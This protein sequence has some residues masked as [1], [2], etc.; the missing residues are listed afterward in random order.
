MKKLQIAGLAAAVI[1]V[2]G[3]TP[4][5]AKVASGPPATQSYN[6]FVQGGYT[7][8]RIYNE[9]SAGSTDKGSSFVAS[10]AYLYFPFALKFDFRQDQFRTANNT[11]Q[12]FTTVPSFGGVTTASAVFD[13]RQSTFDGRLE[14]QLLDPHIYLGV[15][16][17]RA[18]NNYGYP[19]LGGL[20]LG[21]EK[22]PEFV[23]A[24]GAHFSAFYYPNVSGKFTVTDPANPN[25]N[26]TYTQAYRILK[27]DVGFDVPITQSPVYVSVGFSGDRYYDKANAPRGQSHTGPYGAIG[28]RF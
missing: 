4:G 28:V 3:L 26:T 5:L 17:L 24:F 12:G 2:A 23:S 11:G 6:G 22:L 16:Y 7:A 9:F 10:G 20:G 15:G 25:F 1:T 14:L 8:G 18:N 21:L 13:A 19:Q 27:Y